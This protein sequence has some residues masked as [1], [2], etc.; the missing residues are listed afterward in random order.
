MTQSDDPLSRT[1]QLSSRSRHTPPVIEQPP[2]PPAT[3]DG[4]CPLPIARC[5]RHPTAIRHQTRARAHHRRLAHQPHR[6]L[7]PSVEQ[8]SALLLVW[9]RRQVL[10]TALDAPLDQLALFARLLLELRVPFRVPPPPWRSCACQS[11]PCIC[12]RRCRACTR[13][14]RRPRCAQIARG[15]SRPSC[16]RYRSRRGSSPRPRSRRQGRRCRAAAR[17]RLALCRPLDLT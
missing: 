6:P 5:P 2:S 16:S 17:R 13:A 7:R 8:Q 9:L 4:Q 14:S 11:A 3:V 10:E 1:T 15:A 12:S